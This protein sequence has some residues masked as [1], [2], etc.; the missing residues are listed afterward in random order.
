MII[1]QSVWLKVWKTWT[2]RALFPS[3]ISETTHSRLIYKVS[4]AVRW[5]TFLPCLIK[6][7]LKLLLL[8][9]CATVSSQY[10]VK[11]L[12]VSAFDKSISI[13]NSLMW[14][15]FFFFPSELRE[16]EILVTRLPVTQ[17]AASYRYL[18]RQTAKVRKN[19]CSF[20]RRCFIWI[21]WK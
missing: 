18:L 6:L 21:H 11:C 10:F 14:S 7:V 19:H 9:Q 8:S 16:R 12:C 2:E 1:Q 4:L 15:H 17:P 20:K 13:C 5:W 3:G